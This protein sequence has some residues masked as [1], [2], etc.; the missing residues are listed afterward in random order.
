MAS[1]AEMTKLEKHIQVSKDTWKRL[2]RLKVELEKDSVDQVIT[3]L[4]DRLEL[5][6]T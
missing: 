3:E 2:S 6:M 4:L 5:E 1:V